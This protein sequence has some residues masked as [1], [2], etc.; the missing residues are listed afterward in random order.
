MEGIF[1]IIGLIILPAIS[2][3]NIHFSDWNIVCHWPAQRAD[4]DD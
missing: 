1:A 2:I 4:V 3:L